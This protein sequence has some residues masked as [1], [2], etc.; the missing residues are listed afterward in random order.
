M[1]TYEGIAQIR[2]GAPC[3][4]ALGAF[5]GLHRGHQVVIRE[6]VNSP[7]I[8]SVF[9]FSQDPSQILEGKTEYLMTQEDKREA[10]EKLGVKN[11]F[12]V[13][14]SQLRDMEPEAFFSEILV[15]RCGAALLSC[16]ENF[17][18]GRGARG[19]VSLLENL[20]RERGV[21]LRVS[22]PAREG[23]EVIS[24]TAIRQALKQGELP[25]ANKM[26]GH[27]FGFTL[28]VTTGNQIGRTLGTPTINQ[29]L[30]KGFLLPK[31]GVYASLVLL[32]GEYHWG[33]TNI[34]TKP[35]VGK[36]DPLAET[37]IGG[38]QGDLYGKRV[39]LALLA[40][41]REERKFSSLEELKGEI[42]RNAQTARDIVEA[43]LA[44]KRETTPPAPDCL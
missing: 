20:C 2:G 44:G 28:P 18:F 12:Q 10:L 11:L 14:F 19:D 38:F 24:S 36:Y 29:I 21:L 42:L 37:W 23:G 35:T 34:G 39:R 9:T 4:V 5:A 43:Y 30:P 40:F 32:E 26:L 25:L 15:G 17:R 27:P 3:A 1:K 33:V 7:W 22:P 41:L 13:D 16:G 8:P 6:A 31:F